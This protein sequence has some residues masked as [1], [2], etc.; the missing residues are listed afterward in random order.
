M[1]A[2]GVICFLFWFS[3]LWAQVPK[4]GNH[5]QV[6]IACWNVEW[7]GSTQFGPTN[8]TLQ[9]DNIRSVIQAT[10]IDI[11]ALEEVSNTTTF[12]N[13]MSQL[14]AYGYVLANFSQTQ[15]TALLYK[16]DIFRRVTS[17][18]ILDQYAPVFASG[19]LP[20]EVVLV[21]D[22]LPG[23]DTLVLL[24]LHMKAHTGTLA[25]KRQAYYDRQAASVALKN[26]LDQSRPNQKIM[27]LGDWNDQLNKS[28]FND[29]V[30]PF[31]NFLSSADY[32]YTTL[33][34]NL[35]GE[36]SLGTFK[37][38][39][40][41]QL[42]SKRLQ[43]QYIS[44]SAKVLYLNNYISDYVNNTSDHFPVYSFF[45]FGPFTGQ[46]EPGPE[47]QVNIYPNPARD[48]I[49]LDGPFSKGPV[50]VV[51]SDALGRLLMQENVAD[52]S[53]LNIPA[54]WPAALYYLHLQNQEGQM[55][56]STFMLL[57]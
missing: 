17:S 35:N 50:H 54:H 34:L 27:A 22:K 37:S 48:F 2:V 41:H 16:K 23:M 42:I 3:G 24:V 18:L 31:Q 19:R 36:Q 30:S 40:D 45:N 39:I 43:Q 33:P 25:E 46:P 5:Q 15:K 47:K 51:V 26:Y 38:F 20:L 44:S 28:I 9:F 13:L 53:V 55:L 1:R 56:R 4:V 10:D 57:R 6:E 11:W 29:T 12:S 8:E 49:R 32:Y 7:F 21:S 14:P 52:N